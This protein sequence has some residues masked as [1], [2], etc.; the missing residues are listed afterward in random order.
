MVDRLLITKCKAVV[1]L[2]EVTC[3]KH[4]LVGTEILCDTQWAM[5]I[6]LGLSTNTST[7]KH[8]VCAFV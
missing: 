5:M 3:F 2:W 8:G 1:L 4:R 7:G 6:A